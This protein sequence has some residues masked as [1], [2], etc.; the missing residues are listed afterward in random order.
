VGG[1]DLG[2]GRTLSVIDGRGRLQAVVDLAC[3][4][5]RFVV[6]GSRVFA[7]DDEGELRIFEI[8]R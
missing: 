5:H 2:P 3:T 6:A 1:L 4:V 8:V 7:I